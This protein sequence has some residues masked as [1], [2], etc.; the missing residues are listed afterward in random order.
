M[1]QVYQRDDQEITIQT[2]QLFVKNFIMDLEVCLW[3]NRARIAF[4]NG[5]MMSYKQFINVLETLL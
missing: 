2:F 1:N 5:E 4:D 3:L